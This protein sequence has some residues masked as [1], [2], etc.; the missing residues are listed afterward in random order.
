MYSSQQWEAWRFRY[1]RL[2]RKASQDRT[3]KTDRK[4]GNQATVDPQLW[5]HS[6]QLVSSFHP[7]NLPQISTRILIALPRRYW[8]VLFVRTASLWFQV[9]RN[10]WVFKAFSQTNTRHVNLI[11][12]LNWQLH[13]QNSKEKRSWKTTPHEFTDHMLYLIN[14]NRGKRS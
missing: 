13:R 10:L 6:T 1:G 11:I 3:W 4:Q 9:G 2:L 7:C 8:V 14:L 12:A 5:I